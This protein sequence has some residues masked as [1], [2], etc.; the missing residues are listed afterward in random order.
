M[1][2]T[3]PCRKLKRE[4]VEKEA[5]AFAERQAAQSFKPIERLKLEGNIKEFV[6]LSIRRLRAGRATGH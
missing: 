1:R 6:R 3:P 2:H 5:A 4:V